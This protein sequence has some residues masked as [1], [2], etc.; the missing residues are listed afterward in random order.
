GN[1]RLLLGGDIIVEADGQ[2]V[3]SIARLRLIVGKR[4]PGE[5]I[6]LKI[7]RGGQSLTIAMRLLERPRYL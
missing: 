6:D 2:T 4:R 1:R 3:D 5:T 7:Y